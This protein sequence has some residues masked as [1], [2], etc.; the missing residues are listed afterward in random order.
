MRQC[1]LYVV[2]FVIS[3]QFLHYIRG[4]QFNAFMS[5]AKK[6]QKRHIVPWRQ[7]TRVTYRLDG[8]ERMNPM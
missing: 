6:G 2:P 3:W 4:M 8:F 1:I 7:D 5:A